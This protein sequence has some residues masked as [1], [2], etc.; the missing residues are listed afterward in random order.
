MIRLITSLM[1][2]EIPIQQRAVNSWIEMGFAPFSVNSSGEIETL[3]P[4]FPRVTFM[5]INDIMPPKV[6]TLANLFPNNEVAGII[7]SDILLKL[8]AFSLRKLGDH[9]L[10]GQRINV[11]NFDTLE[12]GS[13]FPSGFDFFFFNGKWKNRIMDPQFRFGRPAWDYYLPLVLMGCTKCLLLES[14]VAFH[15]VHKKRWNNLHYK[16]YCAHFTSCMRTSTDDALRRLLTE[17]RKVLVQ[18]LEYL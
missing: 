1:P 2:A 11:A 5:K 10:F 18:D 14:A 9:M 17:S 6:L 12:G 15:Q 16:K 8:S 13:R 7:N 3:R 4:L